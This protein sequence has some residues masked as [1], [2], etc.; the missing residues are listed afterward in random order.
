MDY[1]EDL[2]I[3][4]TRK[5]LSSTLLDMMEEQSLEKISVIDLCTKALVNRATFYAHFEDKYHLLTFALEELKD[6]V[7][8]RFSKDVKA[9][10]PKEVLVKLAHLTFDFVKDNRNHVANLLAHNRNEKVII[11]IKESLTQSVKYQLGKFNNNYPVGVPTTVTATAFS[12]ALVDLCLWYLDNNDKCT[13]TEMKSF[14]DALFG[15][16]IG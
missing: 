7:Y 5:L 1:K 16:R 8:A 6:E 15:G 14:V 3:I 9:S 4:R 11:T 2:R 12:G 10:S 13:E